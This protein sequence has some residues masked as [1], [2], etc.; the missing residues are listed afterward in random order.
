MEARFPRAM[1]AAL[2]VAAFFSL[3][4]GRPYYSARSPHFIVSAPTAQLAEEICKSAEQYRRDLAIEWLGHELPAWQ[5]PCPIRADV[6]QNLGA[7]G[8]TSFVFA[9]GAPTQ[10]TMQIQGSRER[11]LDSVLPHEITHTIFATHFGRPLPRW[12]DEGACTTVEHT[13]E[14][15]KQDNFLIQFLTSNPPRSIP[16]NR[17]FA[18]KD[19]PP[20]MLPLYS[21][22]YSLTRYLIYQ[23][24][25]QKF[26]QYVGEGMRTNNWPAVTQ[27]FYGFGSLSDLQL[28]WLEWVRQGSPNVEGSAAPATLI[29]T[30]QGNPAAVTS[31]TRNIG[32]TQMASL[33]QQP[34]V[35]IP[36]GAR[37]SWQ[38]IQ[39]QNSRIFADASQIEAPQPVARPAITPVEPAA[40]E[41]SSAA[42]P[43][44]GG[45]YARRRDQAQATRTPAGAPP[46][47]VNLPPTPP[48]PLATEAEPT[49]LAARPKVIQAQPLTPASAAPDRR[50]L[51]EWTRSSD[52][53]YQPGA[54]LTGVALRDTG[55]ILR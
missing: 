27:K 8:A 39:E 34:Q 21:Q 23:G 53:P 50:V 44:S 13:S 17:M 26:V 10:W 7:G 49:A 24:G 30:T 16:F 36:D 46:T 2:V 9:G 19:Y 14:K 42:R 25:K 32:N 31:P 18:M 20:D 11:I 22:G 54:E 48:Q 1:R 5:S 35:R 38:T 43:V 51:L 47:N 3:G 15:A 29:A 55:T 52:R 37:S 45:W 40:A 4:A 33:T 6:A 41:S 12:A 28:T